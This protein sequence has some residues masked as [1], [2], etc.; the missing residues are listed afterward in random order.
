VGLIPPFC[1]DC[2]VAIGLLDSENQFQG[3]A[4]GFLYGDFQK[5]VKEEL[6]EYRV[7]LVTNRHVFKGFK[8]VL[9]RFNPQKIDEPARQYNLDLIDPE[10]KE[11][12]LAHPNTDI[13]VAVLPVN[14]NLLKQHS[15]KF[16]YFQSDATV[17]TLQKL[18][19][20]GIMEGDF[21]YTLGF[22]MSLVGGTRNVV[23]ARSGIIARIR[24][25]LDK[26]NNEYLIDTLIFPGNSGGPVISKPEMT[27]IEGTKSQKASYLVGIVKQYV[28]YREEAI[29]KQTGKTRVIFEENSGLAVVHPID[30][31]EET[32]KL[33]KRTLKLNV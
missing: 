27:H 20:L 25:T 19:D 22:P 15:I 8:K 2:V 1:F 28:A 14:V 30:F 32:I 9:V 5:K 11:L 7:Y 10:G 24:D 29:S 31:V 18:V 23:I 12:W 33:S 13:D 16:A 26:Q 6:K 21:V 3:I 17:A 4:S